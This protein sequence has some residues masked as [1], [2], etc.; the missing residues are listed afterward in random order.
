MS[1]SVFVE[2]EA[3]DVLIFNQLLLHSSERIAS[4]KPR[5]AYR[6]SFQGFEQIFTPRATPI[7]LRGGTPESLNK[8]YAKPYVKPPAKPQVNRNKSLV[9]KFLNK[10]G[11]RLQKL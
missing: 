2:L 8:K 5:R 4:D 3:G 11:Y 1:D 7:V 10:V 6:I 9:V